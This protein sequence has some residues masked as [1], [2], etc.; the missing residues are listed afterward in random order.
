M[1]LSNVAQEPCSGRILYPTLLCV[2][3]TLLLMTPAAA[4]APT[5][6]IRVAFIPIDD[7]PATEQFPQMTASICGAQLDLSPQ[8]MLGHYTRPDDPDALGRWM[9]DLDTQAISALVVSADM[10]AYGGSGVTNSR[11]V[12]RRRAGP[13][14]SPRALSR[15]APND[16]NLCLRDHHAPSADR[17]APKRSLL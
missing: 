4:A 8:A 13:S 1:T 16:S 14:T 5:A 10:L 6:A 15:T 2:A 12:T 7:R 11:N 9:L 3:L 17:N